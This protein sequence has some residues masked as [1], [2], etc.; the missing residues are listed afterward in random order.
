MF[1]KV[2]EPEAGDLV[3][4]KRKGGYYHFG[5]ASGPNSIIHFTDIG[6]DIGATDGIYIRETSLEVFVK[7]DEIEVENHDKSPFFQ[8]EIVERAR[9]FIGSQTFRNKTYNLVT[10]NCEHFA[11]YIFNG[12]AESTQISDG[13]VSMGTAVKQAINTVA[14]VVEKKIL[15]KRNSKSTKIVKTK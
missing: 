7:N 3:R 14:N 15:R 2:I 1:Y 4:V 6:G 10:N 13:S 5:I 11:R 12:I 9:S 8:E